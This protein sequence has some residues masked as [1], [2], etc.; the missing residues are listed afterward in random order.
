[1]DVGPSIIWL[2]AVRIPSRLQNGV[3]DVFEEGLVLPASVATFEGRI[4]AS[5]EFAGEVTEIRFS[6][7]HGAWAW[8][9]SVVAGP[10]TAIVVGAAGLLWREAETC[11]DFLETH[12][13]LGCRQTVTRSPRSLRFAWQ[14]VQVWVVKLLGGRLRTGVIILLWRS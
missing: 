14:A 6:S 5:E 7:G 1:M 10:A 8:I 3:K 9:A 12:Y 4:L 2:M 11:Q 13:D